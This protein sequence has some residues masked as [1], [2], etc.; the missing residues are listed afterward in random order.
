MMGVSL[1]ELD[2]TQPSM[3]N[4]AQVEFIYDQGGDLY[5]KKQ[6]NLNSNCRDR[7]IF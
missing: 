2:I 5:G 4:S 3:Y 6:R 7:I 1:G